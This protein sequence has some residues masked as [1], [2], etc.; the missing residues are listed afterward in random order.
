MYEFEAK[1]IKLK[2][3]K[4]KKQIEAEKKQTLKVTSKE[5]EIEKKRLECEMN[6]KCNIC[7][8]KVR[9]EID[10]KSGNFN[11]FLWTRTYRGQLSNSVSG[12]FFHYLCH[13]CVTF[14][15][16]TFLQLFTFSFDN[17]SWFVSKSQLGQ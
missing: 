10:E 17:R 15:M 7:S 4:D 16:N 3:I 5:F 14:V 11:R 8:I 2:Q 13:F 9:E 1:Q 6:R 12:S